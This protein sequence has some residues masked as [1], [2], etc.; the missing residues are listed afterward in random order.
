MREDYGWAQILFTERMSII[1]PAALFCVTH[2]S[3]TECVEVVRSLHWSLVA[4]NL[5]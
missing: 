1:N 5:T 3:H 4:P 2:I